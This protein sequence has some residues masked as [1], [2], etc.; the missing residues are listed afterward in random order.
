VASI[1]GAGSCTAAADQQKVV[2]WYKGFCPAGAAVVS[3]AAGGAAGA[4]TTAA[5]NAPTATTGTGTT[6]GSI[7]GSGTTSAGPVVHGSW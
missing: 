7:A 6:G 4:T 1:C 3:S 2:N 5:G